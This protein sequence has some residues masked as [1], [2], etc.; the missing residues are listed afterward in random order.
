MKKTLYLYLM[1]G[2][3]MVN[4]SCQ[5]NDMP[6]YL[7]GDMI[8]GSLHACRNGDDWVA[9][10]WAKRYQTDR[11]FFYVMGN[12]FTDYGALRENFIISYIPLKKGKYAI[13]GDKSP[14][15]NTGHLY[16]RCFS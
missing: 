6:L 8:H 7:P 15:S 16:A 3:M 4:N 10:G 9:S 1:L 12:T 13:D 11:N 2:I 14:V 5:K